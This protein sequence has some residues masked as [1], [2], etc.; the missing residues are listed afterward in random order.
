MLGSYSKRYR[1][2]SL[3]FLVRLRL[4]NLVKRSLILGAAILLLLPACGGAGDDGEF[5]SREITLIVPYGPGGGA[6]PQG[7]IMAAEMERISG[8]P[9]VVENVEGGGGTVG[10][11]R[12]LGS[13]PDGYTIALSANSIHAFQPVMQP[14]LSFQSPDDWEPIIR[15]GVRDTVMAAL[16]DEPYDNW[17][18][19]LAYVRE[20]PGE[21]RSGHTG[22]YTANDVS[23]RQLNAEAGVE[24]VGVPFASG[25]TDYIPALL[26]GRTETAATYYNSIAGEVEAGQ[27]KM[28]GCFCDEP[29][30]AF[31]DVQTIADAGYPGVGISPNNY[32]ITSPDVPEDRL[33]ALRQLAEEALNTDKVQTFLKENGFHGEAVSPSEIKDSVAK[34][35]Q[36]FEE[37]FG[38]GG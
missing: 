7:R 34:D 27:L 4:E 12:M 18:E 23:I 31:P 9:V 35:R 2:I 17:D 5:P 33:E 13:E 21:V 6:D 37:L 10:V 11:A 20:N 36:I 3:R 29:N 30:P 8:V 19:F 14:D 32:L 26:S 1:Q 22:E 16:P 24:I 25:G 28:I 15:I 38:A